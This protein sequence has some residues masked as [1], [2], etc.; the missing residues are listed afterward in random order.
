MSIDQMRKAYE[1]NGLLEIDI[2]SDPMVQF[3]NWFDAA[4]QPDIPDWL[5]VNAMTLST[6][7]SDGTVTSRIVLLKGIENG[8]LYF[9]TNY[10]SEKGRQIAENPNVSLCFFWPHLE[11]Q[12][13]IDG[14]A[15]KTERAPS[16]DY[17]HRRPRESQLG[18]L[19]S[20]QSRKVASRAELEQAVRESEEKWE[21]QEIP[22]PDYWGGYEVA[23]TRFEFWQGRPG[24]LHDRLCYRPEGDQW[25]VSRLSP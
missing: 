22:C 19:V 17:F 7:G 11:R 24:R 1:R 14:T 8:H 23:P 4:C 16:S 20:K 10:E 13:R 2:H 25:E 3:R 5:E 12:V 21:G 18:A 15:A 9:F 6:A